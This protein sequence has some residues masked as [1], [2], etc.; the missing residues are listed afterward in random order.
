MTL[1]GNGSISTHTKALVAFTLFAAPHGDPTAN[2]LPEEYEKPPG[3]KR[4]YGFETMLL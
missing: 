3:I 2:L 4:I 1:S